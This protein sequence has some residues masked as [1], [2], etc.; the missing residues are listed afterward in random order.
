M[1]R[2]TYPQVN[3]PYTTVTREETSKLAPRAVTT[4][5]H[6]S[7]AW[8]KRNRNN[9]AGALTMTHSLEHQTATPLTLTEEEDRPLVVGRP[10]SIETQEF[11][12]DVK[13]ICETGI[14]TNNG[15]F[16][17]RL[18]EQ[19]RT[20]LDVKHAI[21][22]SNAT[23]GLELLLRA[24]DLPAEGEVLLPSYTFIATAHA[25]IEAG[26]RPVFCDVDLN[27]HLLT[28]EHLESK[29][30]HRTAAILAVNLWGLSCSKELTDFAQQK[31]IP[32]I[33][34][35]AHAFGAADS[36]GK[37]IGGSGTAH[38]FS[39]HATKLFNSFEG[40][41]ITT[42]DSQLALRLQSMRNFGIT[43]QDLVELW[44]T[45]A[46]MSEIHAA[47]ALRQLK[48][49]EETKEIFLRNVHIYKLELSAHKLP[50]ITLWNENFMNTGC[51]HAYV[52][53]RIGKPAPITR[54]F[55]IESLRTHGIYAKR[56]FFP[57]I[58][59]LDFYKN[60]CKHD[61]ILHNTETLN[62][63]IMV[64]PTGRFIE[65]EDVKRVITTIASL[66][67]AYATTNTCADT[68]VNVS[69]DTS[70]VSQRQK[71]VYNRIQELQGQISC[72]E[73]ELPALSQRYHQ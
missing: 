71:Y 3:L 39:M 44:G 70:S 47:F 23:K 50:G 32:V 45:N 59:K 28:P 52:C 24:L 2:Y 46:K 37:L 63:E 35:S 26:L 53:V 8:A 36:T 10:V 67:N 16:S 64:L 20:Y 19:I 68:E 18:E 69:V 58:H 14:F 66:Y 5:P 42:N 27:T 7:A 55:L 13:E 65:E 29:I 48:H 56:Y 73:D 22:V 51:T 17:M 57:G 34:D 33:F 40:G 15:P 62:R 49:I 11:Q 30:S 25:V 4:R 41:C 9:L 21:N 60:L 1:L 61:E 43:G 6:Y 12:N 31:N 72:Y 38:V 54:D